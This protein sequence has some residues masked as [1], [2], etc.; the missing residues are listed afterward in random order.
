ME[1]PDIHP[2]IDDLDALLPILADPVR[3]RIITHLREAPTETVSLDELTTQLATDSEH[4]PEYT[5]ILL[6]H[7]H[8]P[9]LADEAI[10]DYDRRTNTVRYDGHPELETLL[11]TVHT[12]QSP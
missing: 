1:Y 7:K 8:L 3:R 6:H 10:V 2:Q 12:H 9:K 5:R 4:D 11:D